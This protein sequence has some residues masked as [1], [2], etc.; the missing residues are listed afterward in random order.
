VRGQETE[1]V[2][3]YQG[4]NN[5]LGTIAETFVALNLVNLAV[6]RCRCRPVPSGC[7]PAPLPPLSFSSLKASHVVWCI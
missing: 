5:N 4:F 7:L 1:Y 2:V 3:N 6:P